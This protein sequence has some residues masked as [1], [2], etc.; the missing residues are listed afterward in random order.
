[1]S[2]EKVERYVRDLNA[3]KEYG[4]VKAERDQLFVENK[5]KEQEIEKL[6]EKIKDLQA[7][8]DGLQGDLASTTEELRRSRTQNEKLQEELAELR[9]TKLIVGGEE[10]TLP[11]IR[12]LVEEAKSDKIK[13]R[14]K[15]L[16][17]E[18]RGEWEVK[19]KPKEVEAKAISD[20]RGII[21]MLMRP[22]PHFFLQDAVNLNLPQ[23]VE[24]LISSEVDR[25]LERVEWPKWYA[26][27]V[28]P[29]IGEL[30][31]LIR[32]NALNQLKGTWSLCCD[33]C[34]RPFKTELR[35]EHIEKLLRFGFIQVPCP[36]PQCLDQFLVF[37]SRHILRP[38]LGQLIENRVASEG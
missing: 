4:P 31:A 1:M 35:G 27:V 18:L 9:D 13:S 37:R 17:N 23:D 32:E 21:D 19:Q 30:E 14:A 16:F 12:E 26:E 3:I 33:K 10:L 6:R 15:Q 2:L 8:K 25:R 20:L 28:Q 7:S 22:E 38:T 29:K 11:R 24:K 34:G 5:L 36:H